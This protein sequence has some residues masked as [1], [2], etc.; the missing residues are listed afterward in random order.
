MLVIILKA[1]TKLLPDRCDITDG[2]LQVSAVRIKKVL[3]VIVMD[4]Q[5]N[6][7]PVVISVIHNLLHPVQPDFRNLPVLVHMI[8][9]AHRDSHTVKA[10]FLNISKHFRS[11]LDAAPAALQLQLVT[12]KAVVDGVKGIAQVPADLHIMHKLQ[13]L[14]IRKIKGRYIH[15]RNL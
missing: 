6:I 15:L 7:H 10:R 11:G 4:I 9:P 8:M 5:D 12:R 14:R 2:L 13:C 3:T 1:L